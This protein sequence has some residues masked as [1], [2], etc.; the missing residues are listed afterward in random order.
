[1]IRRGLAFVSL[2]LAL[3]LS[4]APGRA[5]VAARADLPTHLSDQEFWRLIDDFS[6]PGG[7]LP[8]RQPRLERGHVPVRAA[9]LLTKIVKPGGVYLGVGPDQNFTY[10]AALEP[11][12][13]LHHRHPARQPAAST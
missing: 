12:H 13:R 2:T 7:Y 10:I 3:V 1:M 5:F 11:Q 9:E 6:E 4:A 8:V